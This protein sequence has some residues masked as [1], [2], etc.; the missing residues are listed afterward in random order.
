MESI[1]VQN[2]K[3]ARIDKNLN[4]RFAIRE[5]KKYFSTKQT[6]ISPKKNVSPMFHLDKTACT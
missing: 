3:N 4:S 5:F 2:E 6:K 1:M